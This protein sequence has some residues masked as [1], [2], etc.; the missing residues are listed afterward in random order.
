MV[1][2]IINLAH[3]LGLE[4]VAEGV[5]TTQELDMLRQFG[6]DQVQGYLISHAL[7]L[8]DLADFLIARDEHGVRQLRAVY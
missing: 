1:K 7:P 8:S 2:V 6:C 4:V 3:S 5:E